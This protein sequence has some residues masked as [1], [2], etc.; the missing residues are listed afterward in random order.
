MDRPQEKIEEI[1]QKLLEGC[2]DRSA[3][4]V[5]LQEFEQ[6]YET[7]Q[8]LTPTVPI[9]ALVN[10]ESLVVAQFSN[11]SPQHFDIVQPGPFTEKQ[12]S[13]VQKKEWFGPTKAPQSFGKF[14]WIEI[15][16]NKGKLGIIFLVSACLLFLINTE[17]FYS[18]TASFLLQSATVFLSLYIIFTVSQSQ[19]LYKESTLLRAGILHT[20]IRH[21]RNI[22]ILGILTVAFTFLGNGIVTLSSMLESVYQAPWFI[23]VS[24]LLRAVFMAV[25]VTMLFDTFFTV[26][27]Y[28][29]DRSRVILERDLIIDILHGEYNKH[30]SASS[31]HIQLKRKPSKLS[32]RVKKTER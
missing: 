17:E 10:L 21:D 6:F 20:Y 14:L 22:T 9:V 2:I 3:I 18:V 27:S 24:R 12:F 29:L 13:F 26:A 16:L 8:R 31:G 15:L 7:M 25:V 23:L 11:L 5:T 32:R 4:D 30:Q 1:C 28:Y 19:T